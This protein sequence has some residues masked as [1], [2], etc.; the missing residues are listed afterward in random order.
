VSVYTAERMKYYDGWTVTAGRYEF[1]L[2]APTEQRPYWKA[3]WVNEDGIDGN[4]QDGESPTLAM[5][6]AFATC[7]SRR[8]T[9]AAT[10]ALLQAATGE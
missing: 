2:W 3:C 9:T 1:F 8:L 7:A 10:T 4:F 5:A 6:A